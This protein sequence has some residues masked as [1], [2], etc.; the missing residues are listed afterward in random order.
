MR[1]SFVLATVVVLTAAIFANGDDNIVGNAKRAIMRSGLTNMVDH[2]YKSGC[3]VDKLSNGCSTVSL[4][5]S[6]LKEQDAFTNGRIELHTK[7]RISNTSY[8][9][10]A[11][12][13][14]HT[15]CPRTMRS[16]MDEGTLH[17]DFKPKNTVGKTMVAC[18]DMGVVEWCLGGEGCV[19]EGVHAHIAIAA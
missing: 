12:A 3:D 11:S 15:Y 5:D 6:G 18:D 1:F 4:N 17:W 2:F 7:N 13:F 8:E 16:A 10:M 14:A 9:S 19:D